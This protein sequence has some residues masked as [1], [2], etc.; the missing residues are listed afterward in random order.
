MRC[1]F[2]FLICSCILKTFGQHNIYGSV[3]DQ[4]GNPIEFATVSL[5]KDTVIVTSALT[6]NT[7]TYHFSTVS[8]GQYRLIFSCVN[9]R[10]EYVDV[11]TGD[12]LNI[13]MTLQQDTGK[14][15]VVSVAAKKPLIERKVDRYI[16][17]AG[18]LVA[19]AS[20]AW[21]ILGK[22]PLITVKEPASI[23][24]A[25]ATGAA[26]Q[27][28][29]RL[30]KMPAEVL[31]AYLKGIA[32]G[33]IE[34]IEIITTPSSEYE[35]DSKGGIINIILKKPDSDGWLGAVQFSSTQLIYNNQSLTG[36]WEYQKNKFTL[37]GYVNASNSRFLTWQD[38]Y[39]DYSFKQLF[40]NVSN[41][42]ISV[43]K[44][45]REKGI[46]GSVG[47]DYGIGKNDQLGFVMDYA[48]RNMDRGNEAVTYYR[49]AGNGSLDSLN[50]SHG[51]NTEH[52][53]YLNAD[54][55]YK[56]Q[57][58]R[59]GQSL[60]VMMSSYRYNEDR[61]GTLETIYKADK[62]SNAEFRDLFSNALPLN[63][64]NRSVTVDH[65]IPW[66]GSKYQLNMG[67]RFGT[68]K[69]DGNIQYGR[70]NGSA[71]VSDL[72]E[73]QLFLYRENVAAVYGT[74]THKVNKAFN[75]RLG[76]RIEHTGTKNHVNDHAFLR[77]YT[78]YLPNIFVF[79]AK[80][81]THQFSYS[82]VEQLQRPSF[83]DVNPFKIYSTDRL[84]MKGD[85]F[86]AP[87]KRYRNELAYTLKG[88]HIFQLIYSRTTNRISTQTVVDSLG[89]YHLQKGNFSD[90]SSL[91]FVASYNPQFYTWLNTSLNGYAGY[92]S[93]AGNVNGYA[94]DGNSGYFSATLNASVVLKK[95]LLSTIGF[96]LS[97]T[98]P[99]NSDNDHIRNTFIMNAFVSK[100]LD[101]RWRFSF[102][103]N[104]IFHSGY[105]RYHTLYENSLLTSQ[106]YREMISG[107]RVSAVYNFLHKKKND[108]INRNSSNSEEKRRIGR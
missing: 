58:S 95:W 107:V 83:F 14:L 35:A 13:N 64:V 91:L 29:G 2:L 12:S 53:G 4:K 10:K 84:Y 78:N 82:F 30:L 25:G 96:D 23:M 55:F 38:L 36:N 74:F 18:Q 85:P 49:S 75:Y 87:S 100:K 28:N 72:N 20:N 68:T 22:S 102:F 92:L 47:I 60:K 34:K 56:T 41:Q 63:I 97:E 86:L 48:W 105:D 70:W 8:P 73:S 93:Y 76:M 3:K 9:Y 42:E 32:A 44:D 61:D 15:A 104:D 40:T 98:A 71:Y 99:F 67:A 79:Y 16:V 80:G 62:N 90:Y 24:L 6:N 65:Y 57:L 94:F 69:N 52:A 39:S 33:S 11:V 51:G 7:G 101:D 89:A 88:K 45:A 37:Y 17:N 106:T 31:A 81:S 19:A 27:I 54:L 66:A 1:I 21:E 77:S 103:V 5:Q 108:S 50:I 46:S 26:V 43:T 59:S